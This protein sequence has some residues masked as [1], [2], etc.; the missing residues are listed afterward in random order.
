MINTTSHKKYLEKILQSDE[1][2]SSK[3][4]Q[5]YLNYLAD[6]AASGKELKEITIAIE[7]FEKE[8]RKAW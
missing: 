8:A 2:S 6:A 3:T 1:F 5:S 7:F 4:Y